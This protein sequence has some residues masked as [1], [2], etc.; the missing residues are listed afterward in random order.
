MRCLSIANVLKAKKHTIHFLC[1]DLPGN[2]IAFIKESGY[3]VTSLPYIESHTGS[4]EYSRWLTR[5]EEIDAQ[6]FLLHC[7][8]ASLVIVD[9]YGIGSRWESL[10][11]ETLQCPIIAI[12]D[13]VRDHEADLIIDQTLARQPEEYTSRAQILSGQEYAILA[14]T[15]CLHREQALERSG[16]TMP[17]RILVSFGGIDEHNMTLKALEQLSQ[18]S[19]QVTVLLSERSPHYQTISR[20]AE[21]YEHITHI[22]FCSKMAEL[23]LQ[24]DIA[25]GAPGTTS[26]ER[27]CLGLPSIIV[28][29]ANNQQTMCQKLA[30]HGIALAIE[31]NDIDRLTDHIEQLLHQWHTLHRNSLAVCDGLGAFRVASAINQFAIPEKRISLRRATLSDA[32]LTFQWQ[33]H[34]DTRR[35]ALTK[36]TPSWEEHLAWFT[37]KL[38]SYTDYFYLIVKDGVN[39]GVVRLDRQKAHH[40]LVSIY[41]D[42]NCYG[43]GLAIA[44][45]SNLDTI[46]PHIHIH[47]TV[48]V[49]NVASQALFKRANYQQV[50]A[51]SF[52]RSPILEEAL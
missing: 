6:Q 29:I 2:F 45:L 16:Y 12:D 33:Q 23:M 40:Y 20:F 36:K 50:S 43:Q 19:F 48:L 5:P 9:H 3:P 39:V 7:D 26:W 22:T 32:Q 47:A 4:Q 8:E 10:V 11:R 18:H 17:P 41:I 52:I 30:Q 25:I 37:N 51:T 34:P 49:E 42:P 35:Y 31:P 24:H 1:L 27:A 28:P 44:A 38:K 21:R 46:H 13:L 15:F 14:P